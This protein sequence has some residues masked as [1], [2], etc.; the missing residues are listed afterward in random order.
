MNREA[1]FGC[2]HKY[3]QTKKRAT[4]RIL[5]SLMGFLIV[6]NADFDEATFGIFSSS[7][8][9]TLL[10]IKPYYRSRN[11]Q[12]ISPYYLMRSSLSPAHGTDAGN[13][14]LSGGWIGDDDA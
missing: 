11:G 3:A 10:L 13:H 1:N 14:I 7:Y 8:T 4:P 9:I 2:I 5:P 12:I 6:D